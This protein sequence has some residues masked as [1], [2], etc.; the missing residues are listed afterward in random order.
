[1]V[2]HHHQKPLNVVHVFK[3]YFPDTGGG[4][5]QAIRQIC[6]A[7]AAHGVK[8]TVLTV[9]PSAPGQLEREEARVI[10]YRATLKSASIPLSLPMWRDFRRLAKEADVLHYHFP[11]PQADLM[12]LSL[13]ERRPSIVTYHSDIV[14]QRALKLI[15]RPMM[16]PFL[17]SVDR[18]VVTSANYLESSTDLGPYREKCVVIPLGIDEASYSRP[19]VE[20]MRYWEAQLGRRFF[21]F[22]GVLRYYKGLQFL[23]RAMQGADYVLAVAGAGPMERSLKSLATELGLSNV[24]FL[25]HIP[26]ADKASLLELCR[27]VVFPSHLRSEAF[28]VTLLEGAMHAKPLVSTELGTGTSYVNRHGETG[29]V[30]KAAD[31][32]ALRDAMDRLLEDEQRAH[33]MGM[34]ARARY[35]KLFTADRMASA[36]VQLYRDLLSTV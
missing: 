8:N 35:E 15:Y 26:D 5:E 19:A 25:G 1:M 34:A 12:H 14:R 24:H 3:T 28:G 27:A 6:L 18:I 32:A 22:I 31:P 10:R 7:T 2:M 4:L 30:V 23:L 29:Y 21:L 9:T 13:G 33:D 36:Y 11:W 16:R 20:R 17:S